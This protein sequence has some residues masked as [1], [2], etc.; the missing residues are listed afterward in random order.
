M[1]LKNLM[2]N[3]LIPWLIVLLIP[4]FYHCEGNNDH[5]DNPVVTDYDGNEYKTVQIGNQ[6]WMAENLKTAHYADG[7]ALPLVEDGKDWISLEYD[8]QAMCNYDNLLT[9]NDIYGA[10]HTR[11]HR[12]T[13]SKK[14]GHSVRCVQDP[15]AP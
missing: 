8:D 2:K 10:L 5:P 14:D 12:F 3:A 11:V 15:R 6:L 13:V 4:V 1:K 7:T 9:G